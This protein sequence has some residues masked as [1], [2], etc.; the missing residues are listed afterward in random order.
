[1]ENSARPR[2]L[3]IHG[4]FYQPPRENPWTEKIERQES[5]AP[6]H[7]WNDRIANECYLSNALSRRLDDYGRVTKLVNNYEW[8]SFNFGPTLISWIEDNASDVYARILE[9]DR[10]SAKRLNGHGNA[11]AQCYN[12]A[13]MPLASRRDQETQIRWGI[14]DF[15]RR[16]G[17]PS[18]GI[19]LPETALNAATLEV[20]VEFGFRFIVL[21]PHQ[22]LRVRSLADPSQWNDVSKGTIPAGFPYRCFAPGTRGKRDPKRFVDVF[23]YD[24]PLSTDVS[25]N[26]LLRNGDGL[27]DAIMLAYPRAGS[28]LVVVATDGEVYGHHEPFADMALSYL[29][30]SAA[31]RRALA[32]TN[33]GAYL[34]GHEPK[35]E[36]ELKPG[37]NGEGTAW[38]CVHGVGRWKEDCGDSAGGRPS[39]NQKWRAPLRAGLNSLRDSLAAQYEREASKLLADPWK[40]R[41]EYI[42]VIENRSRDAAAAFVAA[43]AAAPLSSAESARILSLLE[44]QR[45]AQLMFTSCGW[46]FSDISGIETVQIMRYAARAIELAGTEHW[47]SLEKKLLGD[48]KGALSNVAG[49]G[50]GAS[51]YNGDVKASILGR[52]C[53][54]SLYAI[55][56]HLSGGAELAEIYGHPI[57]PLDEIVRHVVAPGVED[58]MRIGSLEIISR[59]TLETAVY[60]YL[61]YVED[62]AT[63][64]CYVRQR[65]SEADYRAM[66]ARLA[67]LAEAGLVAEI[68][69]AASEYFGT[70]RFTIRDFL[71]ED[72]ERILRRFAAKRLE[73]I[74]ARFGEI[75]ADSKHLLIL[76]KEANIPVPQNLLLPVQTH[77]TKK[78]VR[79]V[80]RWERSLT[81]AGLEGIR[82]IVTEAAVFGVPIDKSPAA[83]SFSD[84]LLEKIKALANELDPE[85]AFALEQ[86]V[87][88]ADEMGI[89]TDFRII[90][91]R[92]YAILEMKISPL[93][94]DLARRP[95]GREETKRAISAFLRLARRFNFNT[96][97]WNARLESI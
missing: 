97:A 80:E 92:V 34:D 10:A 74:E 42:G 21:S 61:L 38:S 72:R 83:A 63:F 60:E 84:L 23:F 46:F 29:I 89:Q 56:S 44:S 66:A 57:R 82:S 67:K 85:A 37:P 90:Q 15:E 28:D 58:H 33:F 40:A 6:Y 59:Y 71:P 18:E 1:M 51:I 68:R 41:D 75:Y 2:H 27:A 78:L 20:L 13:I 8:I 47:L 79:E 5:A 9:A 45:N 19:W 94:D 50:T 96:D 77:L 52:P 64:V 12:H 76:L 25:F 31:P 49:K 73:V 95:D 43:H 69:P 35:F 88:L 22:A 65:R 91:N 93:I 3:I 7:D 62:E 4:H 32:M 48:L 24:A 11:I 55:S 70:R 14:H 87:N 53:F 36:V 39:W 54:V 81:P 26:H 86:F 17:R 30:E 16:F